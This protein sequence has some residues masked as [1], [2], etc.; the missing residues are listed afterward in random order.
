MVICLGFAFAVRSM[1]MCVDCDDRCQCSIVCGYIVSTGWMSD[2]L[3]SQ[4]IGAWPTLMPLRKSR[5]RDGISVPS[6]SGSC[7]E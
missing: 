7:N 5:R 2:R 3:L 6:I 1:E 4:L